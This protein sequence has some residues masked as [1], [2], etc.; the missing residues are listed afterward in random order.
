MTISLNKGVASFGGG[1]VAPQ[2]GFAYRATFPHGHTR[3]FWNNTVIENGKQYVYH[4][5]TV[6]YFGATV[7]LEKRRFSA[8]AVDVWELSK[9]EAGLRCSSLIFG[10]TAQ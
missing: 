2:N 3:S 1:F 8:T 4:G 6:D 9:V 7:S 10:S 5:H